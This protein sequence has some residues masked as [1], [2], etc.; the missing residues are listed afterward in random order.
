MW[1]VQQVGDLAHDVLPPCAQLCIGE[2][3]APELFDNLCLLLRRELAVQQRSELVETR[4]LPVLLFG[5]TDERIGL[6]TGEAEAGTDRA[7]N[8]SALSG[9]DLTVHAQHFKEQHRGCNPDRV[10]RRVRDSGRA[11]TL[12]EEFADG[13]QHGYS[14]EFE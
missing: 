12:F 2:R 1:H 7:P 13:F 14:C 5:L 9:F 6:L 11:D 3:N 4:S 10:P 8:R